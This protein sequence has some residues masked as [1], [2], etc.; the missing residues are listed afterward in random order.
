LI[1]VAVPWAP[2]KAAGAA[3]EAAAAVAAAPPA[4]RAATVATT[5]ALR[6]DKCIDSSSARD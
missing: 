4:R 3:V 5:D 6:Q 2:L 1:G